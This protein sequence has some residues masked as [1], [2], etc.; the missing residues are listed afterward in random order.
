MM[1]LFRGKLAFYG[2][3]VLCGVFFGLLGLPES[4]AQA[5]YTAPAAGGGAGVIDPTVPVDSLAIT[6]TARLDTIIVGPCADDY[7]L[8]PFRLASPVSP[9]GAIWMSEDAA[10]S[11]TLFIGT[12]WTGGSFAQGHS[13]VIGSIFDAASTANNMA[14]IH[15]EPLGNNIGLGV[16]DPLVDL[17]IAASTIVIN[18]EATTNSDAASIFRALADKGT[19]T[20]A[21]TL[22]VNTEGT[23]SG[24]ATLFRIKTHMGPTSPNQGAETTFFSKARTAGTLDEVFWLDN[25]GHLVVNGQAADG[26]DHSQNRTYDATF[27]NSN[28][29]DSTFEVNGGSEFNGSLALNFSAQVADNLIIGTGPANGSD[30]AIIFSN[31]TSPSSS[32]NGHAHMWAEDVSGTTEI[33]VRDG[34]GTVSNVSANVQGYPDELAVD[35]AQPYVTY[36]RN[37]YAGV[38]TWIAKHKMAQ[39]IEALARKEGLLAPD[40]YIIMQKA[41]EPEP[42]DRAEAKPDWLIESEAHREL[43][44]L[45]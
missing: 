43:L 27:S 44:E 35:L 23:I 7:S 1:R 17:D 32:T 28:R 42:W 13:I 20:T 24:D 21:F 11:D 12:G 19:N 29:A 41:F 45:R 2:S 10:A 37:N 3:A 33:R 6:H 34:G 30:L 25:E 39:L 18:R 9:C 40:E 14:M 26:S 22:E 38:E 4:G 31:G 8:D 5:W 16:L 15:L 36:D